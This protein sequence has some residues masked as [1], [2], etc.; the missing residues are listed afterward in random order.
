M[1]EAVISALAKTAIGEILNKVIE[2]YHGYNNYDKNY[3]TLYEFLS[4]LQ[5]LVSDLLSQNADNPAVS[6]WLQSLQ[7]ELNMADELLTN[8]NALP[9]AVMKKPSN[10]KKIMQIMEKIQKILGEWG[11]VNMSSTPANLLKFLENESKGAEQCSILARVT[12]DA[13]QTHYFDKSLGT[14]TASAAVSEIR[15]NANPS[16]YRTIAV[17]GKCLLS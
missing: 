3:D 4:R 5:P 9:P 11:V 12:R 1:A 13:F 7:N 6:N 2:C 17:S 8:L 16:L 14:T 10:S 15:R